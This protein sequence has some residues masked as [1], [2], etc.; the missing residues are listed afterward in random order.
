MEDKLENTIINVME[1]LQVTRPVAIAFISR[2]AK[3][4][5]YELLHNV[6]VTVRAIVIEYLKKE[7]E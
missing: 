7:V 6:P 3:D 5:L 4:G 1:S 2:L